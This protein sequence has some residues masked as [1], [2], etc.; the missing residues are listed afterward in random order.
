M[1]ERGT[2]KRIGIPEAEE[3]LK[4]PGVVILDVRDAQSYQ[5]GH[6]DGAQN[7]STRNLGDVVSATSK[8]APVVIYC[9][10][11]N[12][13]QEYSKILCDFGFKDVSSLDGG[14]EA[15]SKRPAA[16]Q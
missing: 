15:W 2:F 3:I 5:K 7:V 1:G 8:A 4:R 13:S 16:L 9:Y 10:K 12:A 14:F 11:G 6:I